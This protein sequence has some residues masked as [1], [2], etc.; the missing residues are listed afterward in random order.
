M[1]ILVTGTTGQVATALKNLCARRSD[2][3]LVAIGR[4]ALEL[5]RP[6]NIAE[7]IASLEPDVVVSAAAWTAVDLAEDNLELAMRINGEGAGQVARGAAMV[8]APVIHLSTDYVYD[9]TK[10]SAWTEDDAVNPLSVY[11]RSKLAGERSVIEQNPMHVILRTAWVY[12]PF[13]KNFVKT[14]LDLALTRD[15]L[16]IVDDQ[17]GSPT[18]A[19]DLADGILSV[20]DKL[21]ASRATGTNV[22]GVYHLAGTGTATWCDL[23]REVFRHSEELKLPSAHIKPVG[24]AAF[25]TKAVRPRNSRLDCSRFANVFDFR[26][27]PWFVSLEKCLEHIAMGQQR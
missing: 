13:G 19:L 18:S 12:S 20:A 11:G 10:P 23:A 2:V 1:K 24:T 8:G 27:P 15:E 17:Y 4:P 3:N 5:D 25:P 9:G 22:W 26:C 6:Q 21:S 14:M 7:T 16:N